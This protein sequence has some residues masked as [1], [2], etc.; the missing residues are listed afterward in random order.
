MLENI[1]DNHC[2]KW[3]GNTPGETKRAA[4][5]IPQFNEWTNRNMERRL[6]YFRKTAEEL[7][8]YLD[9]I[10]I[11]DGSSDRSLAVMTG[12]KKKHPDAFY[13]ASVY[14][15][16]NKV[17]ALYMTLCSVKHE[18]I[19]LSD[20]DTDV[21]G[22]DNCQEIADFLMKDISFM[23]CYFR[24]LP[25]EGSGIIFAFQQFE[26]TLQRWLYRFHEKDHT[27]AVM[28]GAGSCYKRKVLFIYLPT[29]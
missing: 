3:I 23:G 6:D 8:E 18:L 26:Y 1:I 27:V 2:L 19:L 15:N 24:L 25:H 4:L 28:P 7:H 14:P 17:G 9:L 12:Y 11:D 5:L 20:F 10:L 22:L 21:S 16:G 29:S 13:L